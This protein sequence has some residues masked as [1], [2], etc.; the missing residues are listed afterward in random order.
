MTQ[1]FLTP[2]SA[3]SWRVFDFHFCFNRF[4]HANRI[5]SQMRQ[6]QYFL[7]NRRLGILGNPDSINA[8]PEIAHNL[9]QMRY[10]FAT[11]KVLVTPSFARITFFWFDIDAHK[12]FLFLFFD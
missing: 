6:N 11:A 12:S 3:L 5:A 1:T 8:I 10:I 9:K 4:V 2:V 7:C